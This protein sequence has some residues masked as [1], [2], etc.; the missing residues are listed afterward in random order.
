[1]EN[2]LIFYQAS[3]RINQNPNR[4]LFYC[5]NLVYQ[6]KKMCKK[7]ICAIFLIF[8]VSSMTLFAQQTE[9]IT[10][11][12]VRSDGTFGRTVT[13]NAIFFGWAQRQVYYEGDLQ[14]TYQ[15]SCL[16]NSDKWTDWELAGRRPALTFT[17]QDYYQARQIGYNLHPRAGI[18][19]FVKGREVVMILSIPNGK[20]SPIWWD[21]SGN[22]VHLFYEIYVIEP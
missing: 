11:E 12:E 21:K 8:T 1:M 22:S 13:V 14:V 7:S 10:Y 9:R 16:F 4:S 3:S 17:L 6:E 19:Y 15:T 2:Y 5:L 20:G 18:K